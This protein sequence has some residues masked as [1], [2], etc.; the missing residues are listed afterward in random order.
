MLGSKTCGVLTATKRTSM[1]FAAESST[2]HVPRSSELPDRNAKFFSFSP[3][4]GSGLTDSSQT[5][6][7]RRPSHFR[8]ISK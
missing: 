8:S 4:A 7:S 3:G 6:S 2:A 5:N 1:N